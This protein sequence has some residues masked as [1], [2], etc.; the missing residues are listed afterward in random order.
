MTIHFHGSPITGGK[1]G[2][3]ASVA[4]R[5][6]GAFVSYAHPQ[7]I[8]IAFESADTVCIDNGAFSKKNSGK[9]TDWKGFYEKFLPKYIDNPKLRFFVIPDDI[10]G[11][12]RANDLLIKHLPKDLVHKASP[13]WHMH[14]PIQRLIK[15]SNEWEYVCIGSSGEYFSIRSE[16]W[17][18]RMKQAFLGLA[19]AG[20]IAK[21]HGLRMLDGRV[22]GN[23]PLNQA[24]S[25]NLAINVG[26]Y[27]AKY[28]DLTLEACKMQ[29]HHSK[30][31]DTLDPEVAYQ[32]L[33]VNGGT[34]EE[35]L[36]QRCAI[37]KGCIESVK[38][39][40]MEAWLERNKLCKMS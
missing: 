1:G 9:E 28:P 26:K 14:E 20:Y 11:D 38:P 37:L 17:K 12:E 5:G 30:W 18:L 4:H 19:S 29:T 24:D 21:L 25:T 32:N 7:Q 2:A 40:T 36:A 16:K 33:L 13:V 6:A 39:L 27:K 35:M 3:I 31:I 34:K 22:L 23:Y 15:L 10:S 8:D